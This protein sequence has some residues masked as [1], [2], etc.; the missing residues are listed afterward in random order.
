MNIQQTVREAARQLAPH[1]DSP[2]LDAELLLAHC[3]KRTRTYLFTWSDKSLTKAQVQCFRQ[4]LDQRLTGQP[5]AYLTGTREFW[6]L[7]LK[8][9][10]DTLI[11]RPDTEQLV[12]IALQHLPPAAHVLDLGTGTGAVALAL[13]SE[14]PDISI[15]A[16]DIDARTLSVAQHNARH[17]Q[18]QNVRFI[19]SDWFVAIPATDSDAAESFDLIVSNPPY[20]AD[21]DPHLQ[22]GDIRF[23]PPRALTAGADGLDDIRHLVQTAPRYLKPGGWLFF[24]H[25]YD[26]GEATTRLLRQAGY[27]GVSCQQ[28][29]SGNDRVSGGQYLTDR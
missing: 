25:G 15:L 2:R 13:A 18:L 17:H 6:G 8:V 5:I 16:S 12:D 19:Q 22:Q 9:T 4:L 10:A 11:P 27:S 29:L 14:R 28:D 23:E 1:S 7:E 21:N 20:I 3:L 26:Q 24:E